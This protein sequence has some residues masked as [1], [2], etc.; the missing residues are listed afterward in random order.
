MFYYE[1]WTT[2]YVIVFSDSSLPKTDQSDNE[3]MREPSP[4]ENVVKTDKRPSR[5]RL[6]SSCP[7]LLFL[8]YLLSVG[9]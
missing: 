9:L 6:V 3:A 8:S 5:R 2:N 7:C 4:S 1:L